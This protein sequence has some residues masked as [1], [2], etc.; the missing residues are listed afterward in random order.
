MCHRLLV[1]RHCL[2]R[3]GSPLRSTGAEFR[4]RYSV[5]T[6]PAPSK[7]LFFKLLMNGRHIV[8]WGIDTALCSGGTV[9]KALY[10]PGQ[11]QSDEQTIS[12]DSGSGIESRYF[13]FA[14]G[15]VAKCAAEDGGL[16]EVRVFRCTGR[17]RAA[18]VLGEYRNQEHYGIASPSGG[19]VECPRDTRY[20]DYLLLDA[21]DSPYAA[22]LFHYRSLAYLH[23]LNLIPSQYE[24]FG[25]VFPVQLNDHKSEAPSSTLS[26][27]REPPHKLRLASDHL[28]CAPLEIS[29]TS[30]SMRGRKAGGAGEDIALDSTSHP[31]TLRP[32]EVHRLA[33]EPPSDPMS[34][35]TTSCLQEQD[36]ESMPMQSIRSRKSSCASSMRSNCP[37]LTPSLLQYVDSIEF[38][39]ED[40]QVSTA[41]PLVIAPASTMNTEP[42]CNAHRMS[43]DKYNSE[44]ASLQSSSVTCSSRDRSPQPGHGRWSGELSQ[45]QVI[46]GKGSRS[47]QKAKSAQNEYRAGRDQV[48]ATIPLNIS[49]AEWLRNPRAQVVE[50]GGTKKAGLSHQREGRPPTPHP[51]EH[52]KSTAPSMTIAPSISDPIGS[53]PDRPGP[54]SRISDRGMPFGN[55]I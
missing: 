5:K 26:E 52:E 19:L 44:C 38:L 51:K 18:P 23:Q 2:P 17:R 24:H 33:Q 8:S 50:T 55:W 6:S 40:I 48:L 4:L 30:A 16:I 9:A 39:D 31:T 35:A 15:Q 20:Y 34:P 3:D 27:I 25:P 13:H 1:C 12:K 37:S 32:S 36:I 22:V 49:E 47:G 45:A 10:Q 28:A 14:P 53:Q 29:T 21:K 54:A 43:E 41:Q 46:S 7:Y 42:E 11:T